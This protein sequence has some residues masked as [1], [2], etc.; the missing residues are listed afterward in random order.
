MT[1]EQQAIILGREP[2]PVAYDTW[3]FVGRRVLVTGAAGSIGES[4]VPALQANGANVWPTDITGSDLF[5]VDYLDVTDQ[6]MVRRTAMGV[7]PDLIFHLA[8][9][10]HAPE[11]EQYPYGATLVNVEGTYNVLMAKGQGQI[12]L[13][14]TCK[15]VHPETAYG[16][17]KL[18][19]ERMVLNDSGTVVRLFNVVPASGNVFEIWEATDGPVP[20]TNCFRFFVS[21]DEAVCALL[22]AVTR[23]PGRYSPRPGMLRNMPSVAMELGY[24]SYEISPRRGDRLVEP[25]MAICEKGFVE[26]GLLRVVSAHDSGKVREPV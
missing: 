23:D 20:V 13:A 22:A 10:K 25:L 5:P 3:E 15:A 8:A 26:D 12:V 9:N 11:G 17:S 1:P 2:T 6:E 18:I 14:S 19:A 21:M 4:L 16:A 7:K 24:D